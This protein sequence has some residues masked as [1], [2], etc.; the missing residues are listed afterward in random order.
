MASLPGVRLREEN[1]ANAKTDSLLCSALLYSKDGIVVL[2][3]EPLCCCPER[4]YGSFPQKVVITT[5]LRSYP[6]KVLH[7]L[8]ISYVCDLNIELGNHPVVPIFG[9]VHRG[10]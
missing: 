1:E 5:L 2:Y 6:A 3:S 9:S 4:Q 10:I 8:C 7:N